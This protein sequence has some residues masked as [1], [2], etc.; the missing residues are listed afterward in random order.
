V[1]GRLPFQIEPRP[2]QAALDQARGQVAQTKGRLR[3]SCAQWAQ[4][5]A[6]VA[7]ADA[8]QNNMAAKAHLQ[9]ARPQVETARAQI[10]AATAAV[11]PSKAAL[12]TVQI[13]VGLAESSGAIMMS[14][15]DS[16]RIIAAAGRKAELV[17]QPTNIAVVDD[18]GSLVALV[19]LNRGW[20]YRLVGACVALFAGSTF[21]GQQAQFPGFQGSVPTGVASPT[22]LLLTLRDAIDR[23]LRANLGLLLS[24]QVSE[25]ARG[26][27]L[28]SLSALLP[29][30]TGEVSE[31]VEQI[32]LKT[33]GIDFHLPGFST[34]TIVGPFDYTDAR[35][36]ASFS[37]FDYSLRKS[38]RAA[39]EGERAA[40][41]S[42]KDARDLVV[43]SV[44]NAYLLVIAGSSRVQALRAQVETDQA[45]YDR[46][47]DQK[48]AGTTAAIDVLR[49][50]V[51]LQQE[52]QQLIA[53]NNQV[54]KD[55]LALGRVIGLPSGQ[56]FEIADTEPY[57]PLA[58]MTPDQ[59]LRTAYEQRADLQSAQASV[60]GAE[61]SVGAARAERYP[62][63]GVA[64]DY[65]ATGT[66][67]GNSNGTF[68]F[69]AFAKFNIFDGGRI[70]G[71]IIQARAAL[72]QRQDELADLRGQIDYQVRAA[73]LDIQS[74]AD[75]VAVARSNLDLA[76]QTL[77]QAQDRFASG[78][79]DTIE[80]VQAQGSVAVANDNLIAAL[81][82][83]NLAK[84]E[85]ARALGSTEQRI[86]KYME[87][88]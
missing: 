15:A 39:K 21:F 74:A 36:Y 46:T 81:Y 3:R 62:N 50:H 24:G 71:D 45:I 86:Q 61:D 65:G 87:V 6:Q 47:V 70:S 28:R 80:V 9:A 59:A 1:K 20:T 31:N 73:L 37:V 55:K 82:A 66:G 40:Q 60:R 14:R 26:E 76:N 84:V 4:A 54:A 63:L 83:H 5:E 30:I 51:E 72:K 64:A 33:R 11:E 27:R 29:Q 32:D 23:G 17:G 12:K 25:A 8:G 22:P 88:K 41:L 13:D 67:L 68:T 53:Q 44:A 16:K 79:T 78:V 34:P 42:V 43:Q 57:S 18:R 38:Y 49:A 85:L 48:R 69:Q 77:T 58:A 19:G 35:A 75:Q 52:Q 7:A 10:T 56:Q 2:F